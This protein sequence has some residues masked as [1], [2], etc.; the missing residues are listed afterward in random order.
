MLLLNVKTT[1]VLKIWLYQVVSFNISFAVVVNITHFFH[2]IRGLRVR[3]HLLN[4]MSNS[5]PVVHDV[6]GPFYWFN[7]SLRRE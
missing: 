3:L 4:C 2:G 6:A 1:T 5:Q 7:K